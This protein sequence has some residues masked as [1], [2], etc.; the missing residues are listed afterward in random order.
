MFFITFIIFIYYLLFAIIKD[1]IF[2]CISIL[3]YMIYLLY[4]LFVPQKK[5]I[6]LN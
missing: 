5:K 6:D 1:K 4:V 3:F 2:L